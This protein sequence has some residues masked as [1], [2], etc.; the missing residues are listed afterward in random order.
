MPNILPSTRVQGAAKFLASGIAVA[1]IALSTVASASTGAPAT[2][3]VEIRKFAFTPKEIIV[4]PGTTVTWTNRDETP[5][6]VGDR[7]KTFMSRG[8]DTGDRFSF[9]FTQPGDYRYLCDLHPFMTGVV[10]VR[11]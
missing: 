6:V 10:H 5:H 4:A 11:K 7:R 2:A 1:V 3:I 9:T 8:L